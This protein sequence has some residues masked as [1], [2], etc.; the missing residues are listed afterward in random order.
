MGDQIETSFI[1]NSKPKANL[2]HV[3]NESLVSPSETQNI[4]PWLSSKEVGWFG[5]KNSDLTFFINWKFQMQRFYLTCP[6]YLSKSIEPYDLIKP[7]KLS[8]VV[9]FPFHLQ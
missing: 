9:F 8:D 4:I 5:D 2:F 6:P 1:Q 7:I 3:G